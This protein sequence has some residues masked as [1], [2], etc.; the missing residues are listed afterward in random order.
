MQPGN[1]GIMHRIPQN[2]IESQFINNMVQTN[3]LNECGFV[4]SDPKPRGIK[5]G[6][7]MKQHETN[8]ISLIGEAYSKHRSA[9]HNR[10]NQLALALPNDGYRSVCNNQVKTVKT[11][12]NLFS[13]GTPG[14]MSP[15][16]HPGRKPPLRLRSA[17]RQKPRAAHSGKPLPRQSW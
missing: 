15:R 8:H 12:S 16:K 17:E 6:N 10:T 13:N 9:R 1:V 14:W 7:N 5:T 2:L 11:E 3:E 4:R